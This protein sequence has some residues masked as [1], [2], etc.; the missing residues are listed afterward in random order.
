M[1]RFTTNAVLRLR[2][3]IPDTKERYGLTEPWADNYLTEIGM[4]TF[5]EDVGGP[6]AT[7]RLRMESEADDLE[8]AIHLYE[9]LSGISLDLAS[10]ERFWAYLTHITCWR[11]MKA[12][13][14]PE[15]E[16]VIQERYF[17]AHG[18]DRGALR[19]G[20]A[21]LWWMAEATHDPDRQDPFELTR[22]LLVNQDVAQQTLERSLSRAKSVTTAILEGLKEATSGASPDRRTF[23]AALEEVNRMGAVRLLESVPAKE[24]RATVCAI[25]RSPPEVTPG[26]EHGEGSQSSRPPRSLRLRVDLIPKPLFKKNLRNAMAPGK[27]QALAR[28]V[29]EAAQHRCAICGEHTDRLECDEVWNYDAN[30]GEALLQ[31]LRAIC[32]KCHQVKHLGRTE[33][34]AEQG[35]VD[36]RSVVQH[37]LETNKASLEEYTD[38]RHEAWSDWRRRNEIRNWRTTYGR[39]A[40]HVK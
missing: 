27:W 23:R 31:E 7:L 28:Q 34:L 32:V 6:D 9:D 1:H 37:F 16:R 30:N 17:F 15:S 2:N 13:W 24:I 22:I 11:Y 5:R 18:S 29:R 12:R 19:N 25:V 14:K 35:T 36:M 8:N 10:D 4:S 38:H 3:A 40:H 21:R 26:D 33:K 39:W 20:L